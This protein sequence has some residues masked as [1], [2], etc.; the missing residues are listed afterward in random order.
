[1]T[2][3]MR[4]MSNH[5][6]REKEKKRIQA[7]VSYYLSAG[8]CHVRVVLAVSWLSLSLSLSVYWVCG[9]RVFGDV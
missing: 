4:R 6:R 2:A 5:K 8:C 7:F 9:V 1:M 3:T